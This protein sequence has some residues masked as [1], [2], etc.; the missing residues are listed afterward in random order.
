MS[1]LQLTAIALVLALVFYFVVELGWGGGKD[2]A[3][4]NPGGPG[5][6]MLS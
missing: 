1:W 3:R 5:T 6:G 4:N 2:H